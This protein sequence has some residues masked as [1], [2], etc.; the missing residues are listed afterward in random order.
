M[1]KDSIKRVG[2]DHICGVIMNRVRAAQSS[3]YYGDYYV[4]DLKD[5]SATS[6]LQSRD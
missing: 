1:I 3:S 2:H 6:I 5:S 4:P